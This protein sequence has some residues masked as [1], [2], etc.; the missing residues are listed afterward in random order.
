MQDDLKG[1]RECQFPVCSDDEC[2]ERHVLTR[3]CEIIRRHLPEDGDLAM[4]AILP[5]RCL[6]LK[7]AKSKVWDLVSSLQG[8]K[9]VMDRGA[10]M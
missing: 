4:G 7:E 8:H 10:L 9:E 1:C 2:E 6:L 3:E 5:L